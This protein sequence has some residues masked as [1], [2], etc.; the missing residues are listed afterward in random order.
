VLLCS[1]LLLA[2]FPTMLSAQSE[3]VK[4]LSAVE[5]LWEAGDLPA[6]AAAWP[7]DSALYLNPAPASRAQ[8]SMQSALRRSALAKLVYI[9]ARTQQLLRQPGREAYARRAVAYAL[10]P[11][12]GAPDVHYVDA[13]IRLLPFP[14]TDEKTYN[15]VDTAARYFGS[16]SS[17]HLEAISMAA[18]VAYN[19]GDLESADSLLAIVPELSANLGEASAYLYRIKAILA[20]ARGNHEQASTL[21]REALKICPRSVAAY[22]VHI[23]LRLDFA[24]SLRE[25]NDYTEAHIQLDSAQQ[26]LQRV[27]PEQEQLSAASGSLL[28]GLGHLSAY[29]NSSSFAGDM[30]LAYSSLASVQNQQQDWSAAAALFSRIREM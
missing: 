26:E 10:T 13:R 14:D 7:S 5:R 29:P 25:L 30:M 27:Q 28:E 4:R 20:Q 1:A 8:E 12:V 11:A 16:G 23:P 2:L 17:L 21:L 6:L 22:S 3:L 24:R 19:Q 15:P 18:T 9:L